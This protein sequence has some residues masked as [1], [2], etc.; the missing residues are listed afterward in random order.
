[1]NEVPYHHGDLRNALIAAA[2]DAIA[3]HGVDALT[4]RALAR[5]VG[6]TH[7]APYRHFASKGHLLAA[8]AEAGFEL[9]DSMVKELFEKADAREAF[10][11]AGAIYV[12]FAVEQ[13]GYFR[14]MYG[15]TRV[16]AGFAPGLDVLGPREMAKYQALIEHLCEDGRS[17]R[18]VVL[19]GWALVHGI[20]TLV[21]DRRLRPD[22]FDLPDDDYEGLVRVITSS[23]LP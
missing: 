19:A 11:A 5:A 18:G 9:L 21:V 6:V 10:R 8:V 13:P 3:A 7:A 1:M 22:M 17:A 14:V 2:V 12:R 23:Y 4:L 16:T 15:P 20:A